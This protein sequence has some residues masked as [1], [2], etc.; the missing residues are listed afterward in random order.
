MKKL[1]TLPHEMGAFQFRFDYFNV[2][3]KT[4]LGQPNNTLTSGQAFG[5]INSAGAQ[6][7]G[8]AAMRFDF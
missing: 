4:N 5:T 2:L 8:Q 7:I 3:N 6:R 1:V